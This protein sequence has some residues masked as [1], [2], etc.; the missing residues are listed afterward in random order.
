M[1]SSSCPGPEPYRVKEE[2][3]PVKDDD[4]CETDWNWMM[5]MT[6]IL[7]VVER[8]AVTGGVS[9]SPTRHRSFFFVALG[10]VVHHSS[11]HDI[12]TTTTALLVSSSGFDPSHHHHH[13]PALYNHHHHNRCHRDQR[14]VGKD[15]KNIS[16]HPAT[17]DTDTGFGILSLY[18]WCCKALTSVLYIYIYVDDICRNVRCI[19]H[20]LERSMS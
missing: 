16:S 18:I 2:S 5:M 4:G 12:H 7:V 19:M 10:V 13:Y 17:C 8:L 14:R 1:S 9:Q 3:H 20:S 6:I 15:S 11:E